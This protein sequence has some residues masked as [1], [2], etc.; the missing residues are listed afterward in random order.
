MKLITIITLIFLS[1]ASAVFSQNNPVKSPILFNIFADRDSVCPGDSVIV[2]ATISGGDGGPYS[3]Y[4]N[5]LSTYITLPYVIYPVDNHVWNFTVNDS[6][7]NQ[8]TD[9]FIVFVHSVPHSSFSSD[10]VVGCDILTVNYSVTQTEQNCLYI[11][12]FGD[13]SSGFNNFAISVNPTHTYYNPGFYDVML[14]AISQYGCKSITIVMSMAVIYQTPVSLFNFTPEISQAGDT[15]Q[16]NNLSYY[17][18]Y[19]HWDFGD[20][21]SSEFENPTHVYTNNGN[22][23]VTLIAYSNH[24]TT[25]SPACS[26]TFSLSKTVNVELLNLENFLKIYPNPANDK[27]NITLEEKATLEIINS[28]GQIVVSKSL[29]ERTNNLNVSDLPGGVYSLRIKTNKGIAVRK[30]IKQ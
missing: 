22:Y 13:V 8:T 23:T 24:V 15:I 20:G 4:C 26:D 3:V 25:Y 5:Y 16:F 2:N 30:L 11:W 19:W 9:N 18:N 14:T 1:F 28:Q 12:D 29:T 17:G 10:T 7:G 6:S 27:L 21:T